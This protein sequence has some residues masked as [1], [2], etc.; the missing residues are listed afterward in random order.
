MDFMSTVKGSLLEGFFPEGW[1]ME[2]IDACC[3]KGTAR[4]AWWNKDFQP[5]ACENIQDF[6]TYMGHEIALQI[7]KARDEGIEL[8]LILP[9]AA[10]ASESEV[11]GCWAHYDVQLNGAPAM[12][13]L[14][15]AENHTCF[16]I[17]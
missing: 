10:Q 14:Y 6:A 15:L 1:D 4:E 17:I 5:V 9:V 13:M 16:F 7:K 12:Q 2:K 3:K 11:V 8:A